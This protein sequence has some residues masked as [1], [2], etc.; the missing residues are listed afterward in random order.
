MDNAMK[1]FESN[2]FGTVRTTVIDGEPWFVA[3]DICR[4]LEI[5]NSRDAIT[6]LDDDEKDVALTDTLG[7]KQEMTIVNEPGLYTLVLG[8]RKPEAKSFKRWI[9]HEVIPSI[10]KSGGYIAGQETM[11]DTELMA[12]ALLVA[13]KQIEERTKQLEEANGKIQIMLPKAE[14]ADAISGSPDGILIKQMAH[15]LTQNGYTTGQNRLFSRMRIDGY[16]CSARGTRYNMPTQDS[17]ERGLMTT[18]ETHFTDKDG[19]TRIEFVTLIT[20]KGQRYFLQ[21]YA[22]IVLSD[23]EIKAMLEEEDIIPQ[24]AKLSDVMREYE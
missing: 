20:P 14:F 11:T 3:A 22:H 10:R 1:V 13:Q 15:L 12:K 18:R 5:K 17:V 19:V 23:E 21:R 8:S 4:A 6:R 24:V 2:E 7:G 9:T 16:L